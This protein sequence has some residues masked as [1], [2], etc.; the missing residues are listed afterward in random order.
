M[1]ASLGFLAERFQR[2]PIRIITNASF[3]TSEN[4]NGCVLS[5]DPVQLTLNGTLKLSNGKPILTKSI[6]DIS[7][8][9]IPTVSNIF[10][11]PSLGEIP[12]SLSLATESLSL[13]VRYTI[14]ASN[15]QEECSEPIRIFSTSRTSVAAI[16]KQ[17]TCVLPGL[18]INSPLCTREILPLKIEVKC[19]GA[20]VFLDDATAKIS[21]CLSCND[22][23]H[24]KTIHADIEWSLKALDIIRG[25]DHLLQSTAISPRRRQ[26][27]WS[28][29]KRKAISWTSEASIWLRVP[30]DHGL[31]PSFSTTTLSHTYTLTVRLGV[32]TLAE[33]PQLSRI[34]NIEPSTLA[35]DV[36]IVVA[37]PEESS[38]V[39]GEMQVRKYSS[40]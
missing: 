28:N 9:V 23:V 27:R 5:D 30:R 1:F 29:W 38:P 31:A 17:L 40:A 11:F 34:Y 4:I 25:T 19:D 10:R 20:L 36:P 3:T 37:Y 32:S 26:V 12:N 33:Q 39:A 2:S 13:E 22:M 21:F 35:F 14:T 18:R 8:E 7:Q 15:Q 24:P 16:A 6:L